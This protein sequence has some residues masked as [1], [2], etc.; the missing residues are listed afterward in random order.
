MLRASRSG[1]AINDLIIAHQRIF[2]ERGLFYY[3]Q[4]A[5]M[6]MSI[7]NTNFAGA[8]FKISRDKFEH[9][10]VCQVTFSF[11]T[12]GNL[13]MIF[14]Y[15]MNFLFFYPS[16]NFYVNIGSQFMLADYPQKVS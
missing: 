2:N 6:M 12:H 14:I 10:S 8:N 13:K 11:L 7:H 16:C 3:K 5:Q 15:F 9:A 4:L 1:Q